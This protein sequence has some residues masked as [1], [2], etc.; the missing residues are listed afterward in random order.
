MGPIGPDRGGVMPKSGLALGVTFN[1][2]LGWTFKVTFC[3]DI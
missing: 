1:Y 2:A 3:A